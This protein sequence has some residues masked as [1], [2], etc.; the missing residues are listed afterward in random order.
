MFL[1]RIDED[2]YL[3]SLELKEA[4]ALFQLVETSRPHLRSWLPW[5]DGTKKLQDSESFISFAL[6]QEAEDNGLHAGIWHKNRLAGVIALN[7]INWPNKSTFLGY[8]LGEC[9][10]GQGL[11]TKACDELLKYAFGELS[12]NRIS[13]RA[14]KGNLKS[15]AVA[16]RLGF[17]C[18]GLLREEE[19][20]YDHYIDMFIFS[21]LAEEYR[22]K[23]AAVQ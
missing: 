16:K 5:V 19:W 8:W 20:L 2:T 23:T 4:P 17:S 22:A 3:K 18:D 1:R 21:L 9:Y 11:I 14:A 6:T 13:I 12:L 7:G 15:Q 10:Q